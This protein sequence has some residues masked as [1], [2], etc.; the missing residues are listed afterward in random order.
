[1]L[2]S[3][4]TGGWPNVR[5]HNRITYYQIYFIIFDLSSFAWRHEQPVAS[6]N[7]E[8]CWSLRARLCC[9]ELCKVYALLKLSGTIGVEA[10]LGKK[11]IAFFVFGFLGCSRLFRQPVRL[12]RAVLHS[13]YDSKEHSTTK[14]EECLTAVVLIHQGKLSKHNKQVLIC[15]DNRQTA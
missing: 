13:H 8:V 7:L 15:Y 12:V 2:P 9:F 1:M 5:N 6:N 3:K 10:S 4:Q 14:K 11:V